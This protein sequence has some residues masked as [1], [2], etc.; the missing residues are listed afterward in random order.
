MPILQTWRISIALLFQSFDLLWSEK[1]EAT[2][3]SFTAF[4]PT[5]MLD[6]DLLDLSIQQE[7]PGTFLLHMLKT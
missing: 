6:K 5:Y 7:R 4:N 3:L 1:M 2:L